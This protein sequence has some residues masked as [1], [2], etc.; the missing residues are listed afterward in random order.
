MGPKVGFDWQIPDQLVLGYRAQT[1]QIYSLLVLPS[2]PYVS[3]L[4]DN[5]H[6]GVAQQVPNQLAL[7]CWVNPPTVL[8]P[9]CNQCSLLRAT[10][11]F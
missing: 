6:P 9:W 8:A 10:Q 2:N 5:Q 11:A 1:L 3:M 4:G 7:G